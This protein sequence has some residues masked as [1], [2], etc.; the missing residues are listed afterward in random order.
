M[1]R[2]ILGLQ[3][4]RADGIE[5]CQLT[6]FSP[7]LLTS[8]FSEIYLLQL[9]NQHWNI[10]ISSKLQFN[11]I[12]LAVPFSYFLD[13]I[14]GF[15]LFKCHVFKRLFLFGTMVLTL[16]VLHPLCSFKE[17]QSIGQISYKVNLLDFVQF[18]D[19][20]TGILT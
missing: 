15:M 9:M 17:L 1:F 2:A 20:S 5:I 13:F 10:L 3:K 11:Q 18:R 12:P 19:W 8:S 4:N 14:L 16:L 7:L 6:L